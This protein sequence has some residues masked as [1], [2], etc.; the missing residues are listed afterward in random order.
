M[1]MTQLI[2]PER[3]NAFTLLW[4]GDAPPGERL[5]EYAAREW[6]GKPHEGETP[7]GV[8]DEVA[9]SAARALAALESARPSV[10]ANREE[11]DRLVDDVRCIRT[12]MRHYQAKTHA[13]ALVLRYAYS[14]DVADLNKALPLLEQS[15]EEYRKLVRLTDTTYREA[16]SV[17]SGSRRIPF[18]GAPGR[19]THWRDCLPFFEKELETFRGNLSR[20]VLA[21]S[22]VDIQRSRWPALNPKLAGRAG[23]LFRVERGASI[24]TDRNAVIETVAPELDGLTGIRIPAGAAREK[25]ARIEFEVSEPAQVLVGF[26]KSSSRNAAAA[27]PI[28]EW[29]PVLWNGIAVKDHP[30]ITVWSHAL[31]AGKGE[32]AL[33]LGAYVVLGFAKRDVQ[34]EPRM[35][36][37]ANSG[38]VR[39]DLD[40]LFE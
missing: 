28:D 4:T 40:W 23:E 38:Q 13:A 24:Y 31:P 1:L 30:G 21:T 16:C 39:T 29:Q 32:L 37:F 12:L 34:L 22:S 27:P 7:A 26:F 10:T 17:H 6:F 14:R 15:V 19:F 11:F 9:A 18:L 33:G 8:A 20:G 35:V 2:N 5:R 3:Y 25:G 36:F